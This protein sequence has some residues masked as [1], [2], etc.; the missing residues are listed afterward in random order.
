MGRET[1]RVIDRARGVDLTIPWLSFMAAN[2]IFHISGVLAS[3][4]STVRGR[5]VDGAAACGLDSALGSRI[6]S[7][8]CGQVK[9]A[10]F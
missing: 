4:I 1:S 5:P 8:S 7:V 2:Y 3:D 6:F 9:Y 10:W